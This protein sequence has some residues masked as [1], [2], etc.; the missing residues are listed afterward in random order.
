MNTGLSE[1]K[2]IFSEDT[3][4]KLHL[5]KKHH[6]YLKKIFK[7]PKNFIVQFG[8]LS[9]HN[10]ELTSSG[11]GSRKWIREESLSQIKQVE[12]IS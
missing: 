12:I 2:K 3:T 7:S 10:I 4:H 8:D 9:F 1:S 6:G 11:H 5:G